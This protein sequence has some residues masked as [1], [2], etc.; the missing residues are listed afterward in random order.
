[1]VP[2]GWKQVMAVLLA[3]YPTVMILSLSLGP[4]LKPLPAAAAMF[5]SN[6]A[7]C[8][9]LQY[10]VMRLVNRGFGFWLSPAPAQRERA[11]LVGT[12]LVLGCYVVFLAIF[13]AIVR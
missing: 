9:L 8:T 12:A 5:V 11:T 13:L 10:G 1:V 3:L 4:L 6:L 7:S 2:A